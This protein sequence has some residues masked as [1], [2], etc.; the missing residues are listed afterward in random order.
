MSAFRLSKKA[1]SELDAILA[2]IFDAS[3]PDAAA[4]VAEE[5]SRVFSLLAEN[6][7]IGHWREDL[8]DK[9]VR[10]WALWSYLIVYAPDTEPLWITSV[11]HGRRDLGSVLDGEEE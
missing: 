8:T 5:F 10:F 6:P 3:G 1:A 9:A 2:Y 7:G 11:L 4:R